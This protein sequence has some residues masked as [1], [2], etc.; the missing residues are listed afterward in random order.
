MTL[1]L[2]LTRLE[3][4]IIVRAKDPQNRLASHVIQR[5]A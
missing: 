5:Q 2:A 3:I 4:Q 1:A